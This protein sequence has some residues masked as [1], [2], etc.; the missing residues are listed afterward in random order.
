MWT[1]TGRPR[2]APQRIVTRSL[3]KPNRDCEM[4][5][6]T[7]SARRTRLT[8]LA[9]EE[10]IVFVRAHEKEDPTRIGERSATSTTST[11]HPSAAIP[12]TT[13]P[14]ALDRPFTGGGSAPTASN[15]G[16]VDGDA[17]RGASSH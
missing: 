4:V 12:S 3:A 13:K 15:K 9:R 11:S 10:T 8:T 7:T 5:R 6:Y 16:G 14:N 1:T 2:R 17:I